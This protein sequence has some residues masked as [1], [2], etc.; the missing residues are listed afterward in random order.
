MA[1]QVAPD[2]LPQFT[3]YRN[4]PLLIP[5]AVNREQKV[6]QV[7]IGRPQAKSFVDANSGIERVQ[8]KV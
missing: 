8:I 6:V 5:L 2:D 4:L 1:L 3:R 7:H